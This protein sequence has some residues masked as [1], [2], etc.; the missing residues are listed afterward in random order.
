MNYANIQALG[1]RS[2][3]KL[4]IPTNLYHDELPAV[5]WEGDVEQL[6]HRVIVAKHPDINN[7]CLI[8]E[9]ADGVDAL[10]QTRWRPADGT[11]DI[12]VLAETIQSLV[13]IDWKQTAP[14]ATAPTLGDFDG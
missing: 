3:W 5:L 12:F 4:R 9:V 2:S 7:I 13:H 11:L 6:H 14:V 1:A 8:T 10:G